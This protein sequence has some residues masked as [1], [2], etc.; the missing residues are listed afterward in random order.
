MPAT[1][2][3]RR[4]TRLSPEIL[5]ACRV[6]IPG[7]RLMPELR[8]LSPGGIGLTLPPLSMLPAGET[9]PVRIAFRGQPTVLRDGLV[10]GYDPVSGAL[11]LSWPCEPS[12]WSS[13]ERRGR[14]RVYLPQDSL[15]ARMP[16]RH[17]HRVWSRLRIVD[18][19]SDLG[20][21]VETI[22]G[23]GYLLPGHRAPFHLDIPLLT[24]RSWE[25]QILWWRPGTGQTVRMGLRILDPDPDLASA[26]GEWLELDRL[27]PPLDLQDLGFRTSTME[28]QFRFRKVEEVGER[29]EVDGFLEQSE[30]GQGERIGV[31][32]GHLLVGAALLETPADSLRKV[33]F[34]KLRREWV[35][36]DVFFG[37][38]E[39][40]IR[41]FLTSGAQQLLAT[42]PPGME[43]LF[44]LAGLHRP[45]PED[46]ERWRLSRRGVIWGWGMNLVRWHIL[47]AEVGAFALQ[48]RDAKPLWVDRIV[49]LSKL[50]AWTLLR[51]WR[52]PVELGRLRREV[53]RW[54]RSV[55]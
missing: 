23:P 29:K 2:E 15:F 8:D 14:T 39:Q 28:G 53:E 34:L 24:G 48:H 55:D 13:L 43:D 33:V 49:R 30:D 6:R 19:A 17:A 35:V 22:G 32:D 47:Y 51:D 50:A 5:T 4:W 40:V 11:G 1:I 25:C 54:A 52:E 38:W 42:C 44:F 12:A 7:T 18:I 10:R 37:L 41:H 45:G 21:Q 3:Q 36:P 27:R 26:L 16:L 9:I 20:F 31:W 46:A